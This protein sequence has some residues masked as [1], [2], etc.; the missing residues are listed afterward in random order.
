[1][2]DLLP[3]PFCGGP[4]ITPFLWNGTLKT[5][6]GGDHECPGTDVMAPVAAWNRRAEAASP[7]HDTTG[8]EMNQNPSEQVKP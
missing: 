1:M 8:G 3:C 5:S 6:C 2:S 7:H 4:A